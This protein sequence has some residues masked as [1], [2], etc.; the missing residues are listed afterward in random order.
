MKRLSRHADR[1]VSRLAGRLVAR[2]SAHYEAKRDR[3]LL[4]VRCGAKTEERR[5]TSRRLLGGALTLA[6]SGGGGA[7]TLAVRGGH[8]D[9]G[10]EGGGST[11]AGS[12][13]VER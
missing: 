13:G 3:P 11:D 4:E 2:W 8:F 6:V 1:G 10:G 7:L 9:A 5:E 12:E